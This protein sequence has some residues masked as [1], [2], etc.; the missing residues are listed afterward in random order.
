M[1]NAYIMCTMPVHVVYQKQ[2]SKIKSIIAHNRTKPE[3]INYL[4]IID[5]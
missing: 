1:C 4:V 3:E 5:A 2:N